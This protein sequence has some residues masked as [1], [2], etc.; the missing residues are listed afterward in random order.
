MSN[1]LLKAVVVLCACTGVVAGNSVNGLLVRID[2]DYEPICV[3]PCAFKYTAVHSGM[4]PIA[5]SYVWK[6]RCTAD[7][8]PGTEFTHSSKSSVMETPEP[9][10]GSY[11]VKCKATF[12][13]GE[14]G[15]NTHDSEVTRGVTILGP[16]SDRIES[17]L[18]TDSYEANG[19]SEMWLKVIFGVYCHDKKLGCCVD[20]FPQERIRRPPLTYPWG[21]P[22]S[23]FFFECG[24]ITDWKFVVPLNQQ[25][26]VSWEDW[27][28]LPVGEVIDDFYQQ[29]RMRINDCHG[30]PQDFHFTER[31]FQKKKS[32]PGTWELVLA[33]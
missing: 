8:V 9:R 16:D 19:D 25:G 23:V 31:H 3:G 28:A 5:D 13:D 1:C 21:G 10:V 20:G 33:P 27:N 22:G 30:N 6:Y 14:M 4:D 2:P 18:D 7:G 29:N 12:P 17:G 24:D 26:E 15:A 11:Q 32:G